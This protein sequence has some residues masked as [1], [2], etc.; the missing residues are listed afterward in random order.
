MP[1]YL[2][3]AP[4][5]AFGNHI[6]WLML[7][8]D[9][10][11]LKIERKDH[12][13]VVLTTADDKFQFIKESIYPKYRT[14]HNWLEMEWTYREQISTH[15]T[16]TH[17]LSSIKEKSNKCLAVLV[18]ATPEMAYKRYLKFNSNLN[19][20]SPNSFKEFVQKF[21]LKVDELKENTNTLIVN[22]DTL[23]YPKLDKNLYDSLI[24]FFQ[25]KSY[26]SIASELH[27]TW[28][29]LHKK[30]ELELLKDLQEIYPTKD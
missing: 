18:T 20:L 19:N 26:Y 13:V 1:E 9:R 11:N 25:F 7:L 23:F 15:I 29:N 27:E 12:P 17:Q 21:N 24:D 3:C 14:W 10:F 8:D 16:F 2:I 6:R 30:A 4:A 22:S 28:Y 5:G